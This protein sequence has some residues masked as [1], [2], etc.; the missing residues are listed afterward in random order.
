M[1]AGIFVYLT[2]CQPCCVLAPTTGLVRGGCSINIVHERDTVCWNIPTPLA[3]F[4][5]YPDSPIC[6]PTP[7]R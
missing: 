6:C 1:K 4:P 5:T 3:H 7:A 2:K